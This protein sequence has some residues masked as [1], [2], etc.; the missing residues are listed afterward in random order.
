MSELFDRLVDSGGS[1]VEAAGSNWLDQLAQ[2]SFRGVPFHVDTIDWTAGDNVVLREYPFADLPTVFRMGKAAEELKFSA[3]VIG[4]DYHRQRAILMDALTGEGT[5]MHPTA[6]A[7]KVFVAGKFTI[8]EAPTAEGGMARFDLTFVRAEPRRYPVG[9]PNTQATANSTAQAAK[10]SAVDGFAADWSLAQQPGWVAEQAVARI[11]DTIGPVWDKVA[12]A[13]KATGDFNNVLTTNYQV[14]RGGLNTLVTSPRELAQ[15]VALMFAL[16]TELTQAGARDFQAAFAWCGNVGSNVTARPFE[17]R[18]V[19]PVGGGLVMYGTG[20]ANAAGVD[21]AARTELN[22][23][24]AASDRLLEGLA[25][26]A[27]VQATAVLELLNYDLA[28]SAR[29]QVHAQCMRLLADSS[30]QR[31]PSSLPA[32]SWHDALL[33]L[34]TAALTDLQARS[35]DLV[36]LTRYTPQGWEPVWL[37]SYKLFGTAA[38]ADEIMEMNPH[39]RHPMLAPPGR[40][41]RIVSHDL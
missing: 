34:H 12:A 8:R 24:Q 29:A 40:A 13:A 15:Q 23:L 10:A 35:R 3:Y 39:I 30:E 22:H 7:M 38:Y 31:A 28:L 26:A 32:T 25:T 5:L 20:K 14:L 21:S 36:R 27:W 19:P 1:D 37:I 17:S 6:G 2:A 11:R 18:I 9:V 4:A 33:A 41:L 16:P